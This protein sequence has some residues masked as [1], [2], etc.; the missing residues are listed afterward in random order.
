MDFLERYLQAVKFWLPRKQQDDIAAELSEDIRSQVDEQAATLG[1]KLNDAEMASIIKRRGRPLLVATQFLPN[2][3]LIGP[4]LFP[5]YRFVLAIVILCSAVPSLLTWIGIAIFDPFYR[6]H[7]GAVVGRA[8]GTFWVSTFFAIGLVTAVFAVLERVQAKS[9]FLEDWDPRK[10][11]P[12][13]DLLR[14]PRIS[15]TID[16]AANLAFI[17]WW[18]TTGWSLTVFDRAGVR[19]EF[20][21]A[22][23][24][25]FWGFLAVACANVLL[26][27]ANLFRPYW[28]WLR[29]SMRLVLDCVASFFFCWLFKAKILATIVAPNVSPARAEH[30]ANAINTNMSRSFPFAVMGCLLVVG[31]ADVGRLIRVRANRTRLIY[32]LAAV[33]LL[34]GI[35]ANT[36][37]Q[38]PPGNS[39]PV[40]QLPSDAEIRELLIDHVDFQKKS[41]GTIVGIISPQG[42]RIISYGRLNQGDS[43]PL[44]GDS[45]FEIGSVTKIFTTLLLADMVHRG[46]VALDDPVAKYLPAQ[47]KMPERNGRQITLADLATH[48]SG[49]PFLP[50]NFPGI[51]DPANF[52]KYMDPVSKYSAAQLY[53]F[54]ATYQLAKDPGS[55]WGYSNLGVGLLG[56]ALARRAG[57][58]YEDLV[59]TRITGPLGM[60]S[61]AITVSPEMKTRLGVGHD[62]HLQPAPDWR[63]PIFAGA[64]SLHST[65]NDLLKFLAA[66]MGYTKSPLDGAISSML[67]TTRPGPNF[68]QALGWWV[69]AFAPV[70][71][72]VVFGGET[73]GYSTSVSYDP[74]TRVGVVVMSNGAPDDGGLAWHLLRPA[75][76]VATLAATNALKERKEIPSDPKLLDLY[77]GHYQPSVGGLMV[78]ERKNDMLLLKSPSSPQGLR[79]HQQSERVFFINEADMTISFQVD[80]QGRVT[81]AVVRFAGTD[82][83]APRVDVPS[84][85]N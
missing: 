20:A 7:F 74:K 69:L 16:L 5:V 25:F 46:E 9:N 27:V 56:E 52:A 61:T 65:S 37:A 42:R 29:S 28:N 79:L 60:T 1:R 66:F 47:V 83:P 4:L 76:P 13:R 67:Q 51:N 77:A 41:V 84:G 81:G 57:M 21:P 45:V 48:T 59:R 32:G 58:T 71:G 82:T 34:A 2:H 23:R 44:D 55:Q 68:N 72:L 36:G 22:W 63:M 11:P 80:D 49:L 43:R 85:K 38:T 8:W 14:I 3:Y 19:I 75:F 33:I 73:L 24:I 18:L 31:L 50:T 26:A 53:E 30:I 40:F 70:D 64:G 62:A 39:S 35:S 15:A 54:L 78:V 6:S 12:V 17:V 10:L